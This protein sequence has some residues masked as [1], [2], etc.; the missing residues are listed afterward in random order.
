MSSS[1]P[2]RRCGWR[3]RREWRFR[4]SSAVQLDQGGTRRRLQRRPRSRSM[5]PTR[6]SRRRRPR[7]QAGAVCL[8]KP[9]P[10]RLHRSES[11]SMEFR[12]RRL[13]VLSAKQLACRPDERPRLLTAGSCTALPRTRC[14]PCSIGATGFSLPL[15]SINLHELLPHASRVLTPARRPNGGSGARQ[16]ASRKSICPRDSA[17]VT[18][19]LNP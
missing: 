5:R 6:G 3:T 17:V 10:P 19:Q 8:T 1:I 18:R 12:W 9:M 15:F 14:T 4:R 13:R 16:G 2:R 11:G 7:D